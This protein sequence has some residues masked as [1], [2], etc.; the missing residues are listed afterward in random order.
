MGTLRDRDIKVFKACIY[1]L[2]VHDVIS[3]LG[4]DSSKA[5][6]GLSWTGSDQHIPA[7]RSFEAF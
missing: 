5:H 4:N 3:N 7:Q 1:R 2:N 6:W